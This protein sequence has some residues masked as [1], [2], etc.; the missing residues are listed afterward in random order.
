MA[1]FV[2]VKENICL[3]FSKHVGIR[4]SNKSEVLVILKAPHFLKKLQDYLTV[5]SESS[6]AI[7]WI[8]TLV[9]GTWNFH[10]YFQQILGF[11]FAVIF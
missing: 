10:F 4:D 9:E 1:F 2:T 6:N 7:L 3:L 8:H 11:F 5:E